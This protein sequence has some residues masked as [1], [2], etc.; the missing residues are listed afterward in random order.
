MPHTQVGQS[1]LQRG[2]VQLTMK[3]ARSIHMPDR[4]V[5][6]L[7][8][9]L[10]EKVAGQTLAF[11]VSCDAVWK[12]G[13]Q[14]GVFLRQCLNH[15]VDIWVDEGKLAGEAAPCTRTANVKVGML[16][17]QAAVEDIPGMAPVQIATA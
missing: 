13:R 14:A 9:A 1:L 3:L 7:H 4:S 2:H 12:E 16:S 15:P 17:E 10:L 5:R 6:V 11:L 8:H